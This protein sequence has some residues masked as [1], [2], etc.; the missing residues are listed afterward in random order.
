MI[1][2][3]AQKWIEFYLK[4]AEKVW[5]ISDQWEVVLARQI[6]LEYIALSF[7]AAA[8]TFKA[9][10]S[11]LFMH[12]TKCAEFVKTRHPNGKFDL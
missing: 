6:L 9:K 3:S 2:E 7:L 11:F 1:S 8:T 12:G 10:I 5:T 4:L